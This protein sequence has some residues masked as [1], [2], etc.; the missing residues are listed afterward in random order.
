MASSSRP[1]SPFT[2]ALASTALLG[3]SAAALVLAGCDGGATCQS[4]AD[5]GGGPGTGG[6]GGAGDTGGSGDTGGTGATG[7]TS[8]TGGGEASWSTLI[9]GDW[10]L[11]PG[12]ELTSDI[13]TL[14]MDHDIYVGAIRPISPPGTHHT[15][16]ALSGLGAG[17]IIYASGV[18]TN[19]VEFPKGVGLKIPAGETVVLQLHVFNVTGS[20]LSGTSGIEIIEVK[21][22]DLEHEADLFLPGPFDFSIPPNQEVTHTG[23]CTVNAKQNVF[24]IFP[25]MHQLGKHFKTTLNIGGVPTVLHDDSY[26]FTHQAFISFAPI[27]LNPGDTIDTE[28][29][30]QNTT[31]NTVGW[32]ESSTSEM[33]FS[34]LYRYPALPG[35]GLCQN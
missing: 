5:T 13:H 29:T 34:I 27:T 26:D 21:P 12:A 31:P 16:L 3:F 20:Q 33:C 24:A 6:A 17:N 23:S 4:C 19:A 8:N 18:D 9:T 14:T 7:G 15:V 10:Q 25:H 30:W 32:G 22:E 35:D 2:R 28:C 11:G 1:A